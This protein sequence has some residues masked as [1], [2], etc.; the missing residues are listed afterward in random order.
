MECDGIPTRKSYFISTALFLRLLGSIY[1]VAFVSLWTQVIGLIGS[2][3]IVPIASY[4]ERAHVQL[5]SEAYWKL[6]TL[7]WLGAND[8][9]LHVWCALGSVLA[10]YAIVFPFTAFLWLLLWGLY[11]SLVIGGQVFLSFQ[12]DVL[13]LEV[14]LLTVL[15]VPLDLRPRLRCSTPP[16]PFVRWALWWLLCRF[17]LLSGLVKIASGDE[18][19]RDLTALEFHYMTQPLPPWTAWFVHHLPPWLHRAS[20]VIM[21][22]VEL[23]VPLLLF[24]P[25]RLR[26]IAA[27]LLISLQVVIIATG[28]YGF[29]NILTIALS[30]LLLDD[31]IFA[32]VERWWRRRRGEGLAASASVQ[33]NVCRWPLWLAALLLA[34]LFLLSLPP[35]LQTVMR[36]FGVSTQGLAELT[37]PI[38]TYTRPF[39][40]VNGYGLF[41]DMTTERPEIIIEGSNDGQTWKPYGFKYKPGDLRRRPTFVAPHMPRLDWQMWFAALGDVRF[42]QWFVNLCVRLLE[43]NAVVL[44]LLETNPFP[45]A[46]PRH[47]RALLYDYD[48]SS[49]EERAETGNWWTRKLV[50]PYFGPISLRQ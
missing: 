12:W 32:L 5:G 10:L 14:G 27:V 21:F 3:G 36:T 49:L 47:I 33:A 48:F 40:S 37:A 9:A 39:R 20:T 13:L 1:L 24:W 50:R 44:D 30:L 15:L 28:N 4:L 41:A 6:P 35:T 8:S 45:D 46:P 7:L 38:E 17:M 19:W 16:P 2:A 43:G 26:I 34:A 31:G 22:F 18:V 11:L 29:F 42:N 25:R 23:I